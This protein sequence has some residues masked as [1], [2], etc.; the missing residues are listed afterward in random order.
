MEQE[1]RRTRPVGW[2]TV[3]QAT[4]EA[5]PGYQGPERRERDQG[6]PFRV[7]Q[8]NRTMVRST[9]PAPALAGQGGPGPR[10]TLEEALDYLKPPPGA[11]IEKRIWAWDYVA[12]FCNKHRDCVDLAQD[13]GLGQP[14]RQEALA[15]VQ[16]LTQSQD[17]APA[18]DVDARGLAWPASPTLTGGL[19]R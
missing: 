7:W 9:D 14:T 8:W 11:P 13:S 3:S 19:R 17:P 18:S 4:D 5:G 12:S 10:E 15:L 2:G 6:R 16:R 1:P